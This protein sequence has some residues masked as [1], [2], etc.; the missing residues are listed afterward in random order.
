MVRSSTSCA[1]FVNSYLD[2]RDQRQEALSRVCSEGHPAVLSLALNMPGA[3]KAPKGAAA[4]FSWAL[5][6]LL[7]RCPASKTLEVSEDALGH[8]AIVASACDPVDI[9]RQ[10]VLLEEASPAAR[11]IDVDVYRN[12]EQVGRRELGLSARRCLLCDQPAVDCMRA[13]RHPSNEV[14]AKAHELLSDFHA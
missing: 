10:A 12:F 8:F 2:A 9:K 4:L 13:K 3:D 7:A 11:L 14:I 6:E 5:H 1:R